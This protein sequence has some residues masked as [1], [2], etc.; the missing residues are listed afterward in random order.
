LVHGA[1]HLRL[2]E[3]ARWHTEVTVH[4]TLKT[5]EHLP[6]VRESGCRALWLGVE[7]LTATLIEKGQSAGKSAEAF[8]ALREAGICLMPMMMFL[9]DS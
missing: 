9:R 2:S 5:K 6:L 8:G 7:G 3:R 4:D 1:L